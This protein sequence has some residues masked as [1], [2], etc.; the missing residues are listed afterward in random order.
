MFM[1]NIKKYSTKIILATTFFASLQMM[2]MEKQKIVNPELT[3][4]QLNL[5]NSLIN[6]LN[7]R[8]E[9]RKKILVNDRPIF[10]HEDRCNELRLQK[11]TAVL[12]DIRPVSNAGIKGTVM[13]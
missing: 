5:L 7:K 9:E 8:I 13:Q 11:L 4:D 6:G 10:T 12:Y 1:R 3:D 2:A